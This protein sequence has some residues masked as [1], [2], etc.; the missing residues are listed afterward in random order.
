MKLF[1]IFKKRMRSVFFYE[2][3]G[4]HVFYNFN[5]NISVVIR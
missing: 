2:A 4:N 5:N 3:A 1:N